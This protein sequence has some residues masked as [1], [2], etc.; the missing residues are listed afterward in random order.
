MGFGGY[1]YVTAREV[2]YVRLLSATLYS[3][4]FDT[5][6]L[7]RVILIRQILGIFRYYCYN[8]VGAAISS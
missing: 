3:S 1:T 7:Q 5:G 8:E 2:R 4:G 6:W